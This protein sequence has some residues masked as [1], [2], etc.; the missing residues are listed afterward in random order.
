MHP[1]IF[2]GPEVHLLVLLVIKIDLVQAA[3]S[4]EIRDIVENA[5]LA[6]S[7]DGMAMSPDDELFHSEVIPKEISCSEDYIDYMKEF[8]DI[9]LSDFMTYS[10]LKS[11]I[12]I[13]STQ[14]VHDLGKMYMGG[15]LMLLIGMC[16]TGKRRLM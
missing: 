3:I 7:L 13:E 1:A 9:L 4:A 15:E 2:L 6:D 11:E 12:D 14:E 16:C 5:V 10:D 8:E